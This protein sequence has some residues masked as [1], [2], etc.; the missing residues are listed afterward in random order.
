MVTTR[1]DRRTMPGTESMRGAP[2][3]FS[4]PGGASETSLERLAPGA[5]ACAGAVELGWVPDVEDAL[6]PEPLRRLCS[7]CPER[8]VCLQ[9]AV[10]SGS[11]GYWAGTTTDDRNRLAA[12][13][14]VSVAHGDQLQAA[15]REQTRREAAH[16]QA[17]A[18]H[19]AGQDSLW[20]Y[21]RG[22]CRC[23]LC[24]RHNAQR[25]GEERARARDQHGARQPVSSAA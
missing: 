14:A 22:G 2:E 11:D 4:Q 7:S 13:G 21:R 24:R 5:A 8:T 25:R 16:D 20:W 10:A 9:A 12:S 17:A 3:A 19:P 1:T 18:L 15:L 23:R 6:V